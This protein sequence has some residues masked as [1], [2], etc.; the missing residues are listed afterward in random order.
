MISS[1]DF[2][3]G[4]T[5]E[6]DGQVYQVIEFQHVKPGKG[7][8][9]V[10][11]KLKNLQT[12]GVVDRTF[13]AGE[14]VPAARVE[15]REMQ[16]LYSSGDDY[17]FMDSENFEQH[18][19]PSAD[20]GPGVRFLKE[21]MTVWIVFY[22]GA[23]I[24]VDLPNSVELKIVET[25][26]GFKGDTATGGTKPAKLETGAVVKVPLFIENGTTIIVDTRTGEYLGRA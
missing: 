22:K 17:T 14:R 5:I 1:N 26:P 19:I 3:N 7:A 15:R 2:R 18:T 9:F 20:I 23:V 21:N 12:G 6:L 10:R 8:A 24:G 11:T 25:E 16:Y 13:N 4:V